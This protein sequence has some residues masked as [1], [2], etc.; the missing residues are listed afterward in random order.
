MTD[1]F[2]GTT[3]RSKTDTRAFDGLPRRRMRSGCQPKP[4]VVG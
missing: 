4:G 3:V 2:A 1:P